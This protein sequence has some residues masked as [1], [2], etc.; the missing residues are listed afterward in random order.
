MKPSKALDTV[1]RTKTSDFFYSA[2]SAQDS[3]SMSPFGHRL[4]IK[5][6]LSAAG[7]ML[8]AGAVAT[9]VWSSWTWMMTGTLTVMTGAVSYAS[10][11]FHASSR[12]QLA[13][14]ILRDIRKHDFETL[15]LA[16][17]DRGDELNDIIRQ[18][19]RTGKV[20]ERE[21]SELKKIENYRREFLGNLSHELKTPIFSIRGFAETLNE[22][23]IEDPEVNRSFVEKI[24]RNADRLNNLAKDLSEIARLETG[25]LELNLSAFSLRRLVTDVV[26]SVEPHARERSITITTEV[27]SDVPPVFGDAS[28][29]RQVVVNLVENAIKYSNDNGSV[30]IRLRHQPS[31]NLVEF[32]VKDKGVGIGKEDIGRVTERFFRVDK[33]RSRSAGGTGLGLSIVKHILAAHDEELE[34]K[35]RPGKGSAFTFNMPVAKIDDSI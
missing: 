26:E 32:R 15:D 16:Q 8:I 28:Q 13:R 27:E 31:R 35:S 4:G 34:I 14:T 17:V 29:L 18:V 3:M 10:T 25:Q 24:I 1:L 22:G 6:G 21:I 12:L 11:L 20:L 33:S 2:L 7:A 19:Y 30:H 23:A 5:I 9:F